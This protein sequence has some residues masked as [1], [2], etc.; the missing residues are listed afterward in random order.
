MCFRPDR[1]TASR[2]RRLPRLRQ[3]PILPPPAMLD[4][5][6]PGERQA[7]EF[8]CRV[9]SGRDRMW[10]LLGVKRQGA[11]V[12]CVVR[13]ADAG[14]SHKLFALAEVSLAETAVHWR[15]YSDQKAVWAELERRH[16][17][18][19]TRDDEG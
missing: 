6:Q 12:L 5:S 18:L 19:S 11:L 13:W 2:R 14:R 3:A 7:H 15:D 8:L 9:T 4:L 16:A 10:D 1:A 17:A